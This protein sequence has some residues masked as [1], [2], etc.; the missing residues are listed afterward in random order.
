MFQKTP[1]H[2]REHPTRGAS[3]PV[4]AVQDLTRRFGTFTAVD[5]VS[6]E[7][8]RGAIF[9]FLGPNGSGKSTVIRMLCGLLQPSGGTAWLDGIDVT[10]NPEAVKERIGYTSQ[11]FSLYEDLTV[12]ENIHFFGKIYGLSG[13]HLRSRRDEV[14][15]L[16]GI[17][18][19][20][21]RLAGRLSGGWKQR[22]AVAC[23]LLH[24]PQI[25]FLDEPTAG[26]DPVARRDL[27][28]LLF[29]LSSQGTTLF[30]TTHYMDEAERCTHVGYIYLAELLVCGHPDE[31][32]AL[33]EV[34][35]P[36]THRLELECDS[37]TQALEILRKAEGVRDATL[38]GQSIHLLVDASL[39][40]ESIRGPLDKAAISSHEIREIGPS[41]EDVFV[42]LTRHRTEELR[43]KNSKPTA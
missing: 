12:E 21:G 28:D 36:G 37:P 41:L 43:E 19:Y 39:G 33:P 13:S 17:V 6:F 7:I 27:W 34:T 40:F 9:G 31:L 24:Q 29:L 30:V 5:S 25:I 14:M 38:F 8:E 32:K 2:L 22:L 16:L 18:P 3:A 4:I 23:A 42:M 15:E 1:A 35:P 26:I 11:K 10:R 20:A